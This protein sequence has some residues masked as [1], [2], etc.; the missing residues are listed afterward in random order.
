MF[1]NTMQKCLDNCVFPD[2]WKQQQLIL[3]P[4]PGKPSL[5]RPICLLNT[6]GKLL[7]RVINSR[8]LE[9]VEGEGGLADTQY[10]FQKGRSTVDAISS[11]REEVIVTAR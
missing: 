4:K 2:I 1:R 6:L 7:E 8:L 3:L 10:G 9:Y 11:A 5:Y